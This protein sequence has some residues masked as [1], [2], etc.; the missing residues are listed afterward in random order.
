MMTLTSEQRAKRR[1]KKIN[2]RT[3]SELP[4]FAGTSALQPFETTFENELQAVKRW[5]EINKRYFASL[6]ESDREFARKALQYEI[7]FSEKHPDLYQE[8]LTKL[9]RLKN[10]VSAFQN[11]PVYVA[12]YWHCALRGE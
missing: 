3:A 6:D 7:E 9:E 8:K 4:L 5:D 1:M 2:K 10:R 12:D 11:N